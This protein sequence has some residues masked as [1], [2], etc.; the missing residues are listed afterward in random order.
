MP[1]KRMMLLIADKLVAAT[2]NGEVVVILDLSSAGVFPE[3]EVGLR[4]LP[5]EARMFAQQLKEWADKAESALP[6]E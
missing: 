4:M 6:R 3:T 5:A 2:L 1:E